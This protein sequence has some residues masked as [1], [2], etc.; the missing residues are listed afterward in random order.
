M[1]PEGSQQAVWMLH[2]AT[3]LSSFSSV[4]FEHFCGSVKHA[5]AKQTVSVDESIDLLKNHPVHQS[6]GFS[7]FKILRLAYL[8]MS[9]WKRT[10]L[11]SCFLYLGFCTKGFI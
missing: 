1:N 2:C 4:V 10:K 3:C 7:V 6:I 5:A 11:V 8:F 9:R